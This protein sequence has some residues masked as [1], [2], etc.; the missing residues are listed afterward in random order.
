V[1]KKKM[2]EKKKQ[3]HITS[4]QI[5]GI[6]AVVLVVSIVAMIGTAAAKSAYL[7]PNHHNKQ[8]DAWNINPDGTVTKVATYTLKHSTDP[9]GIGIDAIPKTAPVL[10]I[11]S[12]FSG[13]VEMVNP[14]TLEYMGVSSGP[15]NLAGVD[16][17]DQDNIVYALKRNSDDL[18]IY[19]WDPVGKTLTQIG[20]K[21]DLPGSPRG[22]GLAFDDSRDILWVSDNPSG[23]KKVRAYDVSDLS[24][25]VEIPALSRTLSHRPVDVAVDKKRNLVYTVGSWTGSRLLSKY[26]VGAGTE[27]T[28]DLGVGGIGVA[29]DEDSGYV[30]ITRG[31]SS[32]GD[33]IQVWD[34]STSP[35]TLVQD[36]PRIGNPAGICIPQEEISYNK[37]NL[38][39]ADDVTTCVNP[40]ANIDYTICFDNKKNTQAVTNVEINDLLPPETNFVSATGTGSYNPGTHSVSWSYTSVPAGA[41]QQCEHLVVTVDPGTTPGTKLDDIC[42]INADQPGTGPTTVHEY[43]NV[44]VT[45]PDLCP[46]EYRWNTS[47]SPNGYEWDPFPALFRSWNDVHFVNTGTGDAYSVTATITCTPVNVIVVDGDV[48]LGD[49]PAGGSAWGKDFFVLEVDMTNPQDPNKGICWD[50]E[51]DD[52]ANVHHVIEDVA[53]YCGEEC[54]NICP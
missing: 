47:V 48:K 8:F 23:R 26:D 31:T 20:S 33:D 12:E 49:I 3:M 19:S 52:A 54:S 28:K 35:W 7:C 9:A 46:D 37:L 44:C 1:K 30:Y 38:S 34:T 36:T 21:I 51:Y 50:V 41:P 16:V 53:K 13:G 10:F 42:T 17:D 25:I 14:I 4:K 39:K 6:F 40:G 18:Y 29:V 2:D 5:L 24:S 27:T 43:T 45:L 11:S 32:S 15:S 22:Y